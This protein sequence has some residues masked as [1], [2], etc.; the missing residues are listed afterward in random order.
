MSARYRL[1]QVWQALAGRP[2]SESAWQQINDHLS[3]SELALFRRFGL[4]DRRHSFRVMQSLAAAGHTEEALLAAALLHDV[5]KTKISAP[6]W[7]RS[8]AVLGGK[9]APRRAAAW[10]REEQSG[11]RRA[12]VIKE[13]HPAWGAAMVAEA[14]SDPLTVNLICRHQETPPKPALNR[15]DGL[16][17]LLQEADSRN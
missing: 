3:K 8:L 14:G 5:G 16:L 11:W 13:Q 15:E 7:A 17:L 6:L 10:S 4:A 12:F 2:L 1:W 9:F